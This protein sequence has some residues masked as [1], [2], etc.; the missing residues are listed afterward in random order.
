MRVAVERGALPLAT[1]R[2]A[3]CLGA[4][5]ELKD[6]DAP[7]SLYA[8]RGPLGE[9][10]AR[11]AG[12]EPVVVDGVSPAGAPTTAKDTVA[13]ARAMKERGVRLLLFAGG[14]GTARDVCRAV[15]EDCLVLGIPAGV[16]I[17]SAVYALSPKSAGR[18]A[19]DLITGRLSRSA[20]KLAEVMDIDEDAYRSGRLSA[21]LYGYLRA[22]YEK[23]RVQSLKSGSPASD[24]ASQAEA[25]QGAAQIVES[26]PDTLFLVG[27]GTTTRAL[28]SA[29]GLEGTLLGVD[30]IQGG[31][32]PE[33]RATDMNERDILNLLDELDK[34]GKNPASKPVKI[35]VTPIGGQGFVFGR[36][37]QQFSPQV[38]WQI[39]VENLVILASSS[40]IAALRGAPLLVDTGDGSLDAALEG[41]RRVVV[42]PER[43]IMYDVKQG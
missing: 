31:T 4:L 22:P 27:A 17:H 39:G 32:H 13:V 40:K 10:A 8:G 20:E 21:R 9:E 25:A 29:L 7:F 5:R 43:Y 41:Y 15:S 37:N 34:L 33:M 35:V 3:E 6:T 14:D 18:L 23:G 19:A 26:E 1:A 24:A 12:I 38:L 36:G 2:A 11:E 28:L 42:G 30:A 16:K